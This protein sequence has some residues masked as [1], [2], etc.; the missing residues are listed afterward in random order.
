[1]TAVAMS[2]IAA[3]LLEGGRT[4]L[5]LALAIYNAYSLSFSAFAS[6][7][8]SWVPVAIL[9]ARTNRPDWLS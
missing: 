1:M 6:A 7:R 5:D 4:A 8:L 2:G 9:H 3:L